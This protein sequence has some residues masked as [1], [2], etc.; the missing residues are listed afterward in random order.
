MKAASPHNHSRAS[1][2]KAHNPNSG[3]DLNADDPTY[4]RPWWARAVRWL[5]ERP[6]ITLTST[7]PGLVIG[8]LIRLVA[9][10][11]VGALLDPSSVLQ[12][13]LLIH[14]ISF[15]RDRPIFA[16]IICA[17]LGAMVAVA[18]AAQLDAERERVTIQVPLRDRAGRAFVEL[19]IPMDA[20]STRLATM[21]DGGADV[22]AIGPSWKRPAT[23]PSAP[24]CLDAQ[25][26]DH[27][28]R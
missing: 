14:F 10:H 9:T 5:L 1:A 24:R 26:S 13:A 3:G 19:C 12:A 4:P 2:D 8:D 15:L 21:R 18:H 28:P 25:P 7:Y 27:Q 23:T 11:G 16:V 6:W 17:A 20:D 22:R